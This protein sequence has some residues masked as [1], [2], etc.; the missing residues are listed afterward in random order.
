M[1]RYLFLLRHAEAEPD[2]VGGDVERALTA[3]GLKS[4]DAVGAGL[5]SREESVQK[6][7]SSTAARAVQTARNIC[8]FIG[9]AEK[10]IV[11]RRE[12]YLASAGD[13]LAFLYALPPECVSLM[14]VGHNPG[15]QGLMN[16][17]A[18]AESLPVEKSMSTATLAKLETE[19]AW[20]DLQPECAR[21]VYL[22]R[23]SV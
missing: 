11:W 22:L 4:I 15:M 17:L 23:H 7:F 2:A 8:P 9:Y 13:L 10:A 16:F 6:I 19:M 20:N 1:K 12:L 18:T 5:H 3:R 14:L 21:L